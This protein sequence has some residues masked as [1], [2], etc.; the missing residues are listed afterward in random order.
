MCHLHWKP[1]LRQRC[2]EALYADHLVGL[3]PLHQSLRSLDE[4]QLNIAGAI[5]VDEPVASNRIETT[6]TK[7]HRIN[8]FW[9]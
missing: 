3:R 7:L 6:D 8:L 4:K 1:E 5:S 9:A 2:D